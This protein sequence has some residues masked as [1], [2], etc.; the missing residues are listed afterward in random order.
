MASHGKDGDSSGDGKHTLFSRPSAVGKKRRSS[1]RSRKEGVATVGGS[2]SRRRRMR[3]KSVRG[4]RRNAGTDDNLSRSVAALRKAVREK[5][6][7]FRSG[8]VATETVLERQYKPLLTE[9]RKKPSLSSNGAVGKVKKEEV[10]EEEQEEGEEEVYDYN[11]GDDYG[12]PRTEARFQPN[13]FSSPHHADVSFGTDSPSVERP[14][15]RADETA[16]LMINEN[17]PHKLTN[18]YMR[19]MV[20]EPATGRYSELDHIYGPRY[21][22]DTLKVGDAPLQFDEDGSILTGGTRY[23][24]SE[25]LY[26]LLFKRMPDSRVYNKS[27]LHA[28]KDLLRK[29]NAHKRGY[30]PNGKIN[31]NTST[32]YKR[33]IEKIFP[34]E[35]S[36]SASRGGSDDRQKKKTGRG[37]LSKKNF[38]S[39]PHLKYWDD[40][41]ELVDRLRLLTA[42]AQ[43]GNTGVRN[44]I[45]NI[46]EELREEKIIS[47]TGNSEFRS[48]LT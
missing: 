25:G 40:P 39:A 24:P 48:L 30:E 22:D 46:V 42:S 17:Y 23:G 12:R 13:F 28:Y 31:R 44:E 2:E 15:A 5:Y 29:T 10:G 37:L 45:I 27:D 7:K 4:G 43:A 47:G 6:A 32:K 1:G 34:V 19:M 36:D 16:S 3:G 38:N 14:S 11:D 21:D 26:E 20:K 8:E 35:T 41:N 9:L 33:V 18:R